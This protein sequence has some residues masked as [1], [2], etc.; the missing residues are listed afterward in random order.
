MASGTLARAA[1]REAIR[2][3]IPM[4][5]LRERI[6]A[7]RLELGLNRGAFALAV[8]VARST[9]E[10]WEDGIKRP[11]IGHR[12]RIAEVLQLADT[13]ADWEWSHRQPRARTTANDTHEAGISDDQVMAMLRQLRGDE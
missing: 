5:P 2:V 1:R 10:K 13:G 8:G 4:Q 3:A 9:V 12:A 7:R 11:W 6:R